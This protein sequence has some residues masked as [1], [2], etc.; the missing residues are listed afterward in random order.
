MEVGFYG[1]YVW[2][3]YRGEIG[4]GLFW[5]PKETGYS[6]YIYQKKPDIDCFKHGMGYRDFKD[7]PRRAASDKV[8]RDK[9]FNIA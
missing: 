4:R 9:A 5:P 1:F 2:R 8:L 6:R 3:S 7:L